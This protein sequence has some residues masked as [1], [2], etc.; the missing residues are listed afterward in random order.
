[1]RSSA[2]LLVIEVWP[3]G[4]ANA[5]VLEDGRTDDEAPVILPIVA[6][7]Q[8]NEPSCAATLPAELDVEEQYQGRGNVKATRNPTDDDPGP[9][10][11]ILR[12]GL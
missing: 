1:M 6:V 8:E 9:N 12:A 5:Y 4:E 3:L 7:G 10:H 2:I 11:R